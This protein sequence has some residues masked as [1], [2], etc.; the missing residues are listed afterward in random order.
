MTYTTPHPRTIRSYV[1][2]KGRMTPG[3]QRALESNWV[4]FGLKAQGD[5]EIFHWPAVFGRQAPVIL[6][7]GFGMGDSLI[8]MAMHSP[9]E[10]F[11]GVEVHPPGVGA[12]LAK[13]Q[14]AGLTNLKVFAQDIFEVLKHTPQ[15]SLNKV[16]LLFP[17]P[18]PKKRHH[19]RRIVQLEFI[20]L[21][22]EKLTPG[23]MFHAATDWQ[24]YAEHMLAVLETC[25]QFVNVF[26]QNQFAPINQR[27]TT[28]FE[29][30]GLKLGH[31]IFD[32]IY[33]RV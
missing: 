20:A 33:Q 10:N 5:R 15:A 25:P 19:K 7:I 26:G 9:N 31:Q 24:P 4:Q 22:A 3:Q 14:A 30:R 11:I 28:K 6:E 21:I 18:W 23:G 8:A 13:A 29:R 16:L 32:M 27:L 12:C 1:L 17:D 2:R